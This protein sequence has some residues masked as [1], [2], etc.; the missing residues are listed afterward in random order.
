[1]WIPERGRECFHT[2]SSKFPPK[3]TFLLLPKSV[4]KTGF[5]DLLTKPYVKAYSNVNNSYFMLL[6]NRK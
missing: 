4:I 2:I 6:L 3:L 5:L 1:M